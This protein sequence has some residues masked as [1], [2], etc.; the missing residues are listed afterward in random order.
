MLLDQAVCEAAA[1]PLGLRQGTLGSGPSRE[2]RPARHWGRAPSPPHT[3][4]LRLG[5]G[6]GPRQQGCPSG[7]PRQPR[8][9]P[10]PRGWRV[11]EGAARSILCIKQ[12]WGQGERAAA[13]ASSSLGLR[14]TKPPPTRPYQTLCDK[15]NL[16]WLCFASLTHGSLCRPSRP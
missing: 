9:R 1:A 11:G 6:A 13:D 12:R 10:S 7:L 3:P 8:G 16:S 14:Q 2:Q 4:H 5:L 15:K